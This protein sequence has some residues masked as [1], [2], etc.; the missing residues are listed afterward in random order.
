[1][2]KVYYA[3]IDKSLDEY[4]VN[5]FKNGIVLKDGYKCM[6]AL[7]HIMES[8]SDG[9]RVKVIIQEG[10]FHQIKRM[11]NSLGKNVVYLRRIQFG[12]I[13]LEDS[14]DEGKYRELSK[15]EIEKIKKI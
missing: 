10:K 14:L 6:P 8:G 15:E 4:D 2:D 11:F 9:S 1:V 12:P 5:R 7:L 13:K 3:E